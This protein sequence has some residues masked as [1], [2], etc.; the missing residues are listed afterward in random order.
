MSRV[1]FPKGKGSTSPTNRYWLDVW[2]ECYP[3]AYEGLRRYHSQI[4]SVKWSTTQEELFTHASPG[5]H[6]V[7]LDHWIF[8]VIPLLCDSGSLQVKLFANFPCIPQVQFDIWP[9]DAPTSTSPESWCSL[10]WGLVTLGLKLNRTVNV[11]KNCIYLMCFIFQITWCDV[12]LNIKIRLLK[13][14]I[15]T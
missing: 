13:K 1:S 15:K 5:E 7:A 4:S 3:S 14:D 6:G 8:S 9:I 2:W 12:I 11:L 10:Q